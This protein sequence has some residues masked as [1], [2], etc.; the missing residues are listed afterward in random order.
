MFIPTLQSFPK[1]CCLLFGMKDPPSFICDPTQNPALA[2]SEIQ[3]LQKNQRK[4]FL[5]RRKSHSGANRP[6]FA[7]SRADDYHPLGGKMP[8]CPL[9]KAS[10]ADSTG[11]ALTAII[12][13]RLFHGISPWSAKQNRT[14]GSG[15]DLDGGCL[16]GPGCRVPPARRRASC[17]AARPRPSVRLAWQ[18]RAAFR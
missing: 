15:F 2:K 6:Q 16:S 7:N 13:R 10:L 18:A 8:P 9:T 4:T 1:R 11:N 5:H 14:Q 12:G 17:A 3:H